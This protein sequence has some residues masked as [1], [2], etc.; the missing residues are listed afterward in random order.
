MNVWFFFGILV[1]LATSIYFAVSLHTPRRSDSTTRITMSAVF[2]LTCCMVTVCGVT[3][4]KNSTPLM[5]LGCLCGMVIPTLAFAR[6]FLPP[7]FDKLRSVHE[8]T[9]IV[10]T[11]HTTTEDDPAWTDYCRKRQQSP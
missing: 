7:P 3:L 6:F 5:V 10:R 11:R 8:M 9:S 1:G 2:Y 4:L